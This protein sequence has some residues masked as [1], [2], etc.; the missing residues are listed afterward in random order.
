MYKRQPCARQS[1]KAA[2]PDGVI[3]RCIFKLAALHNYEA[4]VPP[5]STLPTLS[6][7][8]SFCRPF[9]FT[10]GPLFAPK[11]PRSPRL[12]RLLSRGVK[13]HQML[14]CQGY[15]ARRAVTGFG[16]SAHT[17]RVRPV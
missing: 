12:L 6:A 2:K 8:H 7:S 4:R 9:H 17:V 1:A 11:W 16:V 15:G 13:S 5:S 14:K 10:L 3:H